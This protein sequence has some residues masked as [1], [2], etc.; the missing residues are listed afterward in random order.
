MPLPPWPIQKKARASRSIGKVTGSNPVFSTK[1]RGSGEKKLELDKRKIETKISELNRELE[2][3]VKERDTQRKK[4][5]KT[6][7]PSIAIVG[8]TNAGKST[9]MNAMVE[10][11]KKPENKKVFEKDM[12]FATLETSVRSIHLPNHKMFFLS[13]TVGFVSFHHCIHKRK[14]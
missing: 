10:T 4:R 6:D 12:L 14:Q 11:Y 13:D 7:I 1:N 5:N 8:Y 2:F 9:L 3:L